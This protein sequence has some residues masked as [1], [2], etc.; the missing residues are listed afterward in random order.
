MVVVGNLTVGGTGKT[1]MVIALVKQ[2]QARG[3]RP[4]IISRGYGSQSGTYPFSVADDARSEIVGDEALLLAKATQCPVII[5][6][7]RS[8][9]ADYLLAHYPETQIIISD[10][11]LQ[12]YRLH[13]DIELVVVDGERGMGNGRC[14][15]AGPLREPVSRLNKVDW[16]LVNGPGNTP[17]PSTIPP[18]TH[19]SLVPVCWENV[20]SG[21]QYPLQPFPWDGSAPVAA[22][23]AIGHPERFFTTLTHLQVTY[24]AVSFDDH[25][26][27]KADDFQHGAAQPV[28]M[29]TKDAVKCVA[30]AKANWWALRVEADLGEAVLNAITEKITPTH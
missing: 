21:Q 28:V 4:G 1:P 11:G 7:N 20:R 5:D 23:A 10:D 16:I 2:L 30:F 27:F 6:P 17:L 19:F 13:R 22:V 15:P 25:H 8:A 14:L 26:L 9:A 29:T 24:N 12:H 3:L 18:Q